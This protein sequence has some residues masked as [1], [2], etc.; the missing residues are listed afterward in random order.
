[1][2]LV[3]RK[4]RDR[5]SRVVRHQQQTTL[6]G[7]L[8]V[9]GDV[10]GRRDIVR[11]TVRVL[12]NLLLYPGVAAALNGLGVLERLAHCADR[13]EDLREVGVVLTVHWTRLGC[14]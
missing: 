10:L 1:V 6:G 5:A 14:D 3:G 7:L 12:N 13:H 11:S 4:D 9:L 2:V 8:R